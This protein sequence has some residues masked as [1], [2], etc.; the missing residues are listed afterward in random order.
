[1]TNNTEHI[2]QLILKGIQGRANSS[3]EKAL[4]EWRTAAPENEAWYQDL[5]STWI[6][7]DDYVPEFDAHKGWESFLEKK[8]QKTPKAIWN[9]WLKVA[10]VAACITLGIL[11]YA[12]HNFT[13]PIERHQEVVWTTD[14]GDIIPLE[15]IADA[16]SSIK[17]EEVTINV[18]DYNNQKLEDTEVIVPKGKRVKLLLE[19]GSKVWLS[20]ETKFKFP[21]SFKG[22][23]ERVVEVNGEAFFDVSRNE[24]QPF[25]VKS[26]STDIVVLGTKFNVDNT[27]DNID[28]TT[29]VSGK[30]NIEMQGK[31]TAELSPSDQFTLIGKEWT[32]KEVDT[33]AYVAWTRGSLL[34]DDISFP[35][36]EK[37][38]ERWYGVVITNNNKTLQQQ[39]FSGE[40]DKNDDIESVMSL[41]KSSNNIN[42]SIKN[43]IVNI[44]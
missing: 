33:S 3:E 25:R 16:S 24:Q 13:S 31:K 5:N 38:L 41:L 26:T 30:V 28:Q 8:P 18:L 20:A 34:F 36:L 27:S 42:Y 14:N 39:R 32:L 35:D 1:M 2:E 6:D 15:Q 29:L 43:N 21:T 17:N 22:Q 40:F 23:R 12:N 7:L 19:D 9:V 44:Y 11:M 4:T 37:K 10:S